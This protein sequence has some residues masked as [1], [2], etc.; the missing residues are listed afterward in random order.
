M[1]DYQGNR[2]NKSYYDCSQSIGIYVG[3]FSQSEIN[4]KD[5]FPQRI[6]D[7]LGTT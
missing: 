2:Y 7:L 4:E 3:E 5:A 6:L 1:A